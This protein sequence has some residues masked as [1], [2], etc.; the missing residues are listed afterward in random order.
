TDNLCHDFQRFTAKS[1]ADLSHTDTYR[2]RQTQP[3]LDLVLENAVFHRQ[4]L[5]SK[6]KFLFDRASDIC[7][8]SLPNHRPQVKHPQFLRAISPSTYD[9][10]EIHQFDRFDLTS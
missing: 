7:E 9:P 8:Q 10:L 2:I 5:V 3:S 6:Q 4:I 1:L